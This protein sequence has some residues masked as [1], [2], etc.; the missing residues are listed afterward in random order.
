MNTPPAPSAG[1]EEICGALERAVL[2]YFPFPAENADAFLFSGGGGDDVKAQSREPLPAS[3]LTAVSKFKRGLGLLAIFVIV[4]TAALGFQAKAQ[5]PYA[6]YLR[7]RKAAS[8]IWKRAM[9]AAQSERCAV[10]AAIRTVATL[11]D[12]QRCS[13]PVT[14]F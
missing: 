3:P 5:A 13:R 10:N 12:A 1:A 6:E 4:T 7:L 8:A 2:R 9:P 11:T 14:L